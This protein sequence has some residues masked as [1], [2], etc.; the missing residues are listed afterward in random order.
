MSFT[1]VYLGS[2]W[3]CFSKWRLP[4]IKEKIWENF[5]GDGTAGVGSQL[6]LLHDVEFLLYFFFFLFSTSE[7][8]QDGFHPAE[9]DSDRRFSRRM[10]ELKC[11]SLSCR[12]TSESVEILPDFP[13]TDLILK[14]NWGKSIFKTSFTFFFFWQIVFLQQQLSQL[15]KY[16]QDVRLPKL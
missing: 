6:F 2:S 14:K 3:G 5:E 12:C 7:A 10:Q 9:I 15:P 4:F 16:F 13:C 1:F 8:G 11:E